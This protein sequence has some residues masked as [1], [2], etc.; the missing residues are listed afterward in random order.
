MC[1]FF[2]G[3]RSVII[4]GRANMAA[5][6][7]PSGLSAATDWTTGGAVNLS[8]SDNSS[9]ET[10]FVIEKSTDGSSYSEHGTAAANATSYQV[11][12]LT[13][14][15]LYYFR[16]KARGAGGDSD[17]TTAASAT[18]RIK[19][20]DVSGIK[21]WLKSDTG[22]SKTGDDVD[23]W[24][25]QSGSGFNASASGAARP[26]QTGGTTL[27]G[28]S[29]I[30]WDGVNDYMS[31]PS[32]VI[33]GYQTWL[34]VAKQNSVVAINLLFVEHSANSNSNPGHYIYG[35]SGNSIQVRRSDTTRTYSKAG[36]LGNNNAY[37][38]ARWNASTYQLWR[39]GSEQSGGTMSGSDPGNGEVTDT[40]YIGSRGGGSFF[41][42][43]NV[44][45]LIAFDNYISDANLT[46]L[47]N[48]LKAKYGL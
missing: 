44:Y 18:P 4:G 33:P 26:K 39:D 19:P 42:S 6:S 2:R 3:P 45:E 17:P 16:V 43:A 47:N 48:Y 21:L 36:W 37:W 29:A 25:D 32:F 14:D 30:V 35:E 12:G 15:T 20:T 34:G 1:P 27:N 31:I 11:T 9:D 41:S 5:P 28:I 10:A 38:A 13:N 7:A 8:W 22:V 40:L 24:A 46:A 23:S